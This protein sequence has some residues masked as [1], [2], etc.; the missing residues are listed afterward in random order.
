MPLLFS[1]HSKAGE[2]SKAG[3][4]IMHIN[5]PVPRLMLWRAAEEER[6]QHQNDASLQHTWQAPPGSPFIKSE[7]QFPISQSNFLPSNYQPVRPTIHQQTWPAP[8]TTSSSSASPEP[9]TQQRGL[10]RQR[11]EIHQPYRP[12]HSFGLVHHQGYQPLSALRTTQQQNRA[13]SC[14]FA[15]QGHQNRHQQ[16]VRRAMYGNEEWGF[17]EGVGGDLDSY[18]VSMCSF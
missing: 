13:K 15:F 8:S 11:D 1:H 14:R 2:N 16:Q 3:L 17:M 9:C 12:H 4:P 6:P 18:E 5:A 7:H 10:K